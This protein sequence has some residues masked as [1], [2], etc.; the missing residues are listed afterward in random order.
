[1]ISVQLEHP[2]HIT[3]VARGIGTDFKIVKELNPELTGYQLPSGSYTLKV[4]EGLGNKT[5]AILKSLGSTTTP[6]AKEKKH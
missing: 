6:A 1:M 4:P 5:L 3:D 2:V